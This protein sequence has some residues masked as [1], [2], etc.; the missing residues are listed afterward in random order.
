M[1]MS[2][3]I[4]KNSGK[5]E[6][7][8]QGLITRDE[9]KRN[10]PELLSRGRACNA[11]IELLKRSDGIWVIKDFSKRNL[12]IRNSWGRAIISY[13]A[14][15]LSKLTGITGFP[16]DA[17]RVD[18]EALA[19]RFIPGDTIFARHESLPGRPFFKELEALVKTMH[20]KNIVHLDLR[21]RRNIL[22][23][24]TQKPYV[25][26]FQSA[27]ST[28][29]IPAA[30]RR[31]FESIDMAGVY[32]HWFRYSPETIGKTRAEYLIEVNRRRSWWPFRGYSNPFKRRRKR[33]YEYA[34]EKAI[35]KDKFSEDS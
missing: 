7:A 5:A 19:Y 15:V 6:N 9:I 18:G 28:K 13:E 33:S 29:H 25:L 16:Q 3:Y 21:N 17:H 20:S 27:I 30:L 14:R 10:T 34:L 1:K 4:E 11:D 31:M 12:I 35:T 32:K 26:D 23:T 22:I 2:T 24:D 8:Q